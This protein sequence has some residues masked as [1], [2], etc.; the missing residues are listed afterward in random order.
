MYSEGHESGLR[1]VAAWEMARRYGVPQGALCW[2]S[3]LVGL[4]CLGAVTVIGIH[5]RG[6]APEAF[7][8]APCPHTSVMGPRTLR[9]MS[10]M[11]RTPAVAE[12]ARTVA[13]L[14][15]AAVA[16]AAAAIARQWSCPPS[17]SRR[18]SLCVRHAELTQR[19]KQFWQMLYMEMDGFVSPKFGRE[20]LD[21]VYEFMRYS[22]GEVPVPQ[23]PEHQESEPE[24]F[25]GLRAKP[26]W[27]PKEVGEEWINEV[28]D[29]L[30][31]VQEELA[32]F[33]E[34]A[35]E[36]MLA[37]SVV[38]DVMGAG[39]KGFRLRRLGEWI[40]SNCERFPKTKLLLEKA[41]APLAMRGVIVARQTPNSGVAPHS[42]GRNCILSA[43]FGLSVPEGCSMT[44]GGVTKDWI[45]DGVI[46]VDTSFQHSTRNDSDE[47]RFVLIVDFWH[48]DLTFEEVEAVEFLY[49]Y[50]NR[51]EQGRIEWRPP[52]N[53]MPFWEALEAMSATGGAYTEERA[54]KVKAAGVND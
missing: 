15:A 10:F 46:V 12:G 5:A 25:P 20:N 1:T 9:P 37:D 7:A 4:G 23:L 11:G 48:P 52:L 26:W 45:D 44:A 31:Y 2:L 33:L 30:P 41:K 39:W 32:D 18:R 6:R 54:A 13:A 50:R 53:D 47:D 14:S 27:E 3:R 36:D 42:D 51:W 40:P 8:A 24:W 49:D 34:E 35:E 29:G 16:A 21:R 38:N 22:K 28:V 43:H 17:S 19:Q